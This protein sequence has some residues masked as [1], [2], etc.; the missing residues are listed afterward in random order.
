MI[1]P[2]T[3]QHVRKHTI[4]RVSYDGDG[5]YSLENVLDLAQSLE[6]DYEHL[7]EE[8]RHGAIHCIR[9]QLEQLVNQ[10]D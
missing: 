8:E 1:D 4:I 2:E 6:D 9:Y 10:H 3:I 5:R 7:N